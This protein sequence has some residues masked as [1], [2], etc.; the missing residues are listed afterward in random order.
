MCLAILS[1][2]VCSTC[3]GAVVI[4]DVSRTS[5][6]A[7]AMSRKSSV[8]VRSL[9]SEEK[10]TERLLLEGGDTYESGMR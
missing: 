8:V 7:S 1:K 6:M 4:V 3:G 2:I 9:S 5:L 10:P